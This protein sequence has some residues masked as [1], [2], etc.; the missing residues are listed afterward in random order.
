MMS[1]VA[2]R[3]G[4]DRRGGFFLSV[5]RER[6]IVIGRDRR[7]GRQVA[8]GLERQHDRLACRAA[9]APVPAR[10]RRSSR[11]PSTSVPSGTPV[12][13]DDHGLR[14]RDRRGTGG[15]A[16]GAD[17]GVTGGGVATGAGGAAAGRPRVAASRIATH[18][19]RRSRATARR[20]EREQRD[21]RAAH[22]HRGARAPRAHRVAAR[23]RRRRAARRVCGGWRAATRRR[24]ARSARPRL[25]AGA[26]AMPAPAAACSSARTAVAQVGRPIRRILLHQPRDDVVDRRRQLG[27]VRRRRRRLR[28]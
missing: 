5:D 20:A 9:A 3:F 17:V 21:P 4:R 2:G 11:R 25:V 28:R 13:R 1:S 12:D 8:V 14:R 24:A 16:G 15:G 27:H 26:S 18:H 22:R 23:L 19:D 7:R 6:L 10:R